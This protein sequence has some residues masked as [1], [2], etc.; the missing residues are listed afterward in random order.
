MPNFFVQLEYRKGSKW[1]WSMG[2]KLTDMADRDAAVRMAKRLLPPEYKV[3]RDYV[4]DL[5]TRQRVS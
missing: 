3:R 2:Y 4:E 1:I 5:E